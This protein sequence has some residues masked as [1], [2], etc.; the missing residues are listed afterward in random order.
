M[1]EA[2]FQPSNLGRRILIYGSSCS[3]KSTLGQE[4]ADHLG[5]PFVELD[6]INWLPG[7]VGLDKTD[8]DELVLR[9]NAATSGEGWVAAGS[10]TRY[11]QASFWPR[12]D[13]LVFLDLP[14]WLLIVRVI[15]RS[16]VRWRTK[17]LLWGTNTESFWKQLAFWRG[18][19]SLIWW[20]WNN[21]DKRRMQV[22]ET[23]GDPRWRH[24][25]I[26]RV[27]GTREV[28]RFRRALGLIR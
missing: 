13:S 21:F 14:R 1:S 12:L 24:I 3:G 8:P 26:I 2:E 25:R 6:A 4:L 17:E 16:W 11:A 28:D 10:Y 18:E 20:I 15:R 9:F 7:W 22:S 23:E 19:D 27:N 5:V